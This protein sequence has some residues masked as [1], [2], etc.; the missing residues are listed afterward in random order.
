MKYLS[1]S[2]LGVP[3]LCSESLFSTISEVLENRE[4]R[5]QSLNTESIVE[6]VPSLLSEKLKNLGFG[7]LS[8]SGVL[9]AKPHP[10]KALCGLTDY[11]SLVSEMEAYAKSGKKTVVMVLESD[12]G[13][14]Y[15]VFSA[16]KRI[17]KLADE[18]NIKLI[19]Y[20]DGN[21]CSAAYAL[22]SVCHELISHD[23]SFSIGSIGVVIKLLNDSKK[24]ENEGYSRTFIFAGNNKI[25]FA[26]DGSF[27]QSFLDDL[28]ESVNSTYQN[29][30]E[31][32]ATYREGMSVD[33]VKN[34]QAK[35]YNAE[36][37]LKIKLVDKLMTQ[38]Q[39]LNYLQNPTSKQ[40]S[41]QASVKS[42]SLLETI[43]NKKSAPKVKT[44]VE[45]VEEELTYEQ[46]K[47]LHRQKLVSAVRT[48]KLKRGL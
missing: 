41:T 19:G 26:Q 38:E 24:L 25:P 4:L 14:A 15:G 45:A 22:G 17:R 46:E 8:V 12:G 10:Y 11:Q 5:Q 36:K 39:F 42:N 20:V 47:E 35:V 32:A 43:R 2:I 18:H 16:A 44:Q 3:Q 33:D 6:A 21:C 27:K 29:F 31:H 34:T 7:V 48:A 23:E 28:Q 1:R 37:A 40:Q 30:V 13:E 9:T